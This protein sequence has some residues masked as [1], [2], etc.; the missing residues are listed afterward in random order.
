MN[1]FLFELKKTLFNKRF[2]YLLLVITLGILFL[3]G[4]NYYFQSYVE[5]EQE[6]K[7]VAEIQYGQSLIRQYQNSLSE[8][9]DQANIEELQRQIGSIVDVLFKLLPSIGSDD[10]E[11]RLFLEIDYLQK[12]VNFQ[13]AGGQ[14]PLTSREIKERIVTNNH[15]LAKGIAPEHPVYSLAVPNFIKQAVDLFATIGAIILLLLAAGDLL[16]SEFEN[17]TIHFLF[18]Q[19]LKKTSIIHSKIWSSVLIYVIMTVVLISTAWLISTLFGSP[20]TF[21]YPILIFDATGFAFLPMHQ[22]IIAIFTLISSVS[23]LVIGFTMWWSLLV[24]HSIATL[25]GVLVILVVGYVMT[26]MIHLPASVNPFQYVLPIKSLLNQTE[27]PWWSAIP[28]TVGAFVFF[29]ILSLVWV[30]KVKLS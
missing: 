11:N 2:A 20:G 27:H 14:F 3:F 26:S 10:W 4:R 29:Y 23:L 17:R 13:E 28:V 5:K 24:K 21:A 9:P 7:I 16:T 6:K 12:L 25:F 22:Y 15:L 1:F 8:N 30:R 18:V 19:P